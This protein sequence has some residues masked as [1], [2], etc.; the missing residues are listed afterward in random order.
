LEVDALLG[1]PGVIS[2][3]YFND[4]AETTPPT[5]RAERD[6]L[7]NERLLRD[8]DGIPDARR[9]ARFV[10]VMALAAPM[11]FRGTGVPPVLDASSNMALRGTGVGGAPVQESSNTDAEHI[12]GRWLIPTHK[13]ERN[14][15]HWERAG[16]TYFVTFRVRAGSLSPAE[17]LI[18]LDACCHW[19]NQRAIIKLVTVMPDHVHLILTPLKQPNGSPYELATLLHSIKSFSAH[20]INKARDTQGPLWQDESFDRIVRDEQEYGNI[21]RYILH[22]PVEAGFATTAWEYPF[23]RSP[24]RETFVPHAHTHRRDAC[25]TPEHSSGDAATLLFSVRG[26]FE[27]RIGTPPHVPRGEHGFGYDPL[28]LVAPD[29]TRTSAQLTPDEKNTCSHRGRTSQL[30]LQRLSALLTGRPHN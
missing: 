18:V 13:S 30:M 26:T 10:C 14:L 24:W 4:G 2:S 6:R 28:F 29:H 8:L 1:K 25:A 15:P 12:D 19:H 16:S 17:K 7:N 21:E 11:S 5:P 22:N 20:A 23:T 3:H 9:T 27:G